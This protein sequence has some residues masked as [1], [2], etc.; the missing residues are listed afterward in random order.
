VRSSLP[1]SFLFVQAKSPV[2]RN[3]SI[4]VIEALRICYLHAILVSVS[5]SLVS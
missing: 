5:G 4:H 1:A 2:S 3:I